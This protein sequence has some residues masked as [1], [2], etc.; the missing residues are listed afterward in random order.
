[1]LVGR[2]E[3]I[4]DLAKASFERLR[5]SNVRVPPVAD[6]PAFSVLFSTGN[7]AQE[8]EPLPPMDY[9]AGDVS[10]IM[11]SSG[12]SYHIDKLLASLNNNGLE[13]S[14]INRLSEADPVDVL[15]DDSCCTY[16]L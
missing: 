6:M 5:A 11:H 3:A 16:V 4:K 13:R 1:M 9:A 10:L 15:Q 2:E 12:S 8:V 7:D 14:R